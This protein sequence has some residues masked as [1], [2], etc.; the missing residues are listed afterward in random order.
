[1]P[2]DELRQSNISPVLTGRPNPP[3][4]E[5]S[6]FYASADDVRL[7]GMVLGRIEVSVNR[8]KLFIFLQPRQ[9]HCDHVNVSVSHEGKL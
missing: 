3:D 6:S 7:Q 2:S 5:P 9:D 4:I 1:M 8:A